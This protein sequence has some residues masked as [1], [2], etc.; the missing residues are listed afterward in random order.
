M[1]YHNEPIRIEGLTEIECL[2]LDIM[3]SYKTTE[4]YNLFKLLLLDHEKPM[5]EKLE[6]LL[7]MEVLDRDLAKK[8]EFT[9]AKDYLKKYMKP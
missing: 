1:D 8:T 5:V 3:W 4:E 6:Q 9:V 2:Y 7:L